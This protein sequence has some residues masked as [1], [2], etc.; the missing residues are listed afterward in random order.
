MFFR[1]KNIK[2]EN[3][4][5]KPKLNDVRELDLAEGTYSLHVPVLFPDIK[6]NHENFRCA[7]TEHPQF[8]FLESQVFQVLEGRQ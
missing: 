3:I 6:T 5:V 1:L 4:T 7:A 2:S 8:A